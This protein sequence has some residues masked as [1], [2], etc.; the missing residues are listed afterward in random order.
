MDRL[1]QAAEELEKATGRKCV[2]AQAD[3]RQP[4]QLRDAVEKGVGALGRIDFVICGKHYRRL[5]VRFSM[6]AY[7]FAHFVP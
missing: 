2:A 6:I 3:V 4:A 1:Q 7:E 5:F